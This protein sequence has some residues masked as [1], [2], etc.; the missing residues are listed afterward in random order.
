MFEDMYDAV[1][2]YGMA[3][4]DLGFVQGMQF[5]MDVMSVHHPLSKV[6]E[7]SESD[8]RAKLLSDFIEIMKENQKN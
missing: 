8:E 1:R 2:D 5:A 6:E 4:Q 3:S 7:Q